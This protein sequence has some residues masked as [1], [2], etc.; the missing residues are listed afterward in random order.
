MCGFWCCTLSC[1][2]IIIVNRLTGFMADSVVVQI[3]IDNF[4]VFVATVVA[5]DVVVSHM[6]GSFVVELV[7][8]DVT[9]LESRSS[10]LNASI[11]STLLHRLDLLRS[12][13]VA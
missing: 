13:Y 5:V 6:I 8:S 2:M 1:E 12:R 4:V 11:A 10:A 9:F 3:A 7:A